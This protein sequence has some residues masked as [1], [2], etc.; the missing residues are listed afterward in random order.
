M[1]KI[2]LSAM[3][4]I[5]RDLPEEE[6]VSTKEL[7]PYLMES[8]IQPILRGESIRY[9]DLDYD[10]FDEMDL[11]HGYTYCEALD[12]LTYQLLHLA[13]SIYELDACPITRRTFF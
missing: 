8:V 3:D 12:S 13:E 9:R 11:Q 4:H 1:Q 2:D 10:Q 5:L 7:N 6:M